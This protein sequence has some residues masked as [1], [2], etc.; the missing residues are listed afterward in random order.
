MCYEDVPEDE[1]ENKGGAP[2]QWKMEFP[3]G[4]APSLGLSDSQIMDTGEQ[5][6][7]IFFLQTQKIFS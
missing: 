5:A 2:P 7:T 1:S 4:V 3:G 6:P